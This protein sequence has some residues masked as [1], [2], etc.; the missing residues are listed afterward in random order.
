VPF[1]G[2]PTLAVA[3]ALLEHSEPGLASNST[4]QGH[5]RKALAELREALK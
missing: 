1:D 2:P 3:L 4:A 5:A